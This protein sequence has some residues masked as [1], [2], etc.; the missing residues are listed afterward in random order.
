[1]DTI[2][3]ITTDSIRL[4]VI[5]LGCLA[6]LWIIWRSGRS[7]TTKKTQKRHGQRKTT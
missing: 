2:Q 3:N 6:S 1:M 4:A 7:I 5:A